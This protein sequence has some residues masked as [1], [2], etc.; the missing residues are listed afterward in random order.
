MKRV[1]PPLPLAWAPPVATH[2]LLTAA[3][4]EQQGIFQAL[5]KEAQDRLAA[6]EQPPAAATVATVLEPLNELARVLDMGRNAAALVRSVHPDAA[7]RAGAEEAERRLDGVATQVSLSRPLYDAICRV[8]VG[9]ASAQVRR[10]HKLTVEELRRSG[11]ALDAAGRAEVQALREQLTAADQAFDG[12]IRNDRRKVALKPAQLAG[13]PADYIAQ[14]PPG[15][16]G[17]C[18]VTTDTPDL[19]PLMTYA[20]DDAARRALFV[21]SRQRGSPANEAVLARLVALRQALARRLGFASWADYATEDQMS[22]SAARVAEFLAQVGRAAHKP[23]RAERAMLLAELQRQQPAAV[24]VGEWQR[25]ALHQRVAQRQFAFDAQAARAYF[26]SARVK[27]G[28]MALAGE[29]FGLTYR[30]LDEAAWHPD[31]ELYEVADAQ[32]P[33][34]RFYLD[35]HPRENKYQHAAAFPLRAGLAGRQLP[36]VALVCNFPA[37]DGALLEHGDVRTFF[38]EFGHLLHHLLAGRGDWVRLSGFATELDFV[39]VPSQLL[40]E[41]TYDESVLARFARRDDGTPIAADMVA[42]LRRARGF[43]RALMVRTQVFYSFLSLE[44][45]LRDA[46]GLDGHRLT[47][48]M[49]AAW[50]PFAPV[51]ETS[52]HLGFGHL[53]GY[54]SNYYAY[55]W[56]QSL[57]QDIFS[58]FRA[59]GLLNPEVAARYRRTVLEP[60]GG[61]AAG[62]LVADFLGRPP[63]ERAFAAWLQGQG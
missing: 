43:G 57:A 54:S 21:A 6:L 50:S 39:E 32:G 16:D 42:A 2:A 49:Q 58:V 28:L 15:A 7:A 36:E 14:H 10:L 30:R 35:L 56:S 61:R 11:V 40:E 34:G 1:D 26:P 13:L 33:L 29:L 24:E 17:L 48:E 41:W 51:P 23:A 52:F 38:H 62:E 45:H 60:G 63:D 20:E 55:L 19:I 59:G 37:G 53:G 4:A 3:A 5:E 8:E 9:Q 25:A 12:N 18:T 47:H 22:G 27:S 44:L 46:E 31:V